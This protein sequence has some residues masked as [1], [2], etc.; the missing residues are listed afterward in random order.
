MISFFGVL[1]PS[2]GPAVARQEAPLKRSFFGAPVDA[3]VVPPA[4][5]EDA[6][7]LSGKRPEP[8][9]RDASDRDDAPRRPTGGV[10]P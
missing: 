6:C 4:M 8:P 3:A 9:E 7:Y 1:G 5:E 10:Q 2:S